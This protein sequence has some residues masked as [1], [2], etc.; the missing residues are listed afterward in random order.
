[1]DPTN[2]SAREKIEQVQNQAIR[3]IAN[4]QGKHETLSSA[5]DELLN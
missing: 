3:L 1:M 5:Y 2:I 4:F